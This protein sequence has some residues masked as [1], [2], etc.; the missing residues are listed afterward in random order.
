MEGDFMKPEEQKKILADI[1]SSRDDQAKVSE[2]L[3]QLSDDYGAINAESV[4]AKAEAEK[5]KKDN[6][7]LRD[8]NM[9]LFLK[10]G[11]VPAQDP[12]PEPDPE[13]DPDFAQLWK[14]KQ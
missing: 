12:D 4:L 2:L 9:R 11:V 5:L 10:V 8:V 14:Q 13:P 6:E 3:T 1:L 7:S